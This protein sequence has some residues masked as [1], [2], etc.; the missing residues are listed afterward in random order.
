MF[1]TTNTTRAVGITPISVLISKIQPAFCGEICGK[2]IFDLD[3]DLDID[4]SLSLMS[5]SAEVDI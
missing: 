5:K 1:S 2:S 4:L 3:I